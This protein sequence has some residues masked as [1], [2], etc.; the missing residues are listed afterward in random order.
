MAAL[1][2]RSGQPNDATTRF[3]RGASLLRV[4]DA[5][6]GTIAHQMGER[7][8]DQIQDL[9]I[10]FGV[11]SVHL[12]FDRSVE[13]SRT[14]RGSF[15]HAFP[16]GCM[17]VFITSCWTWVVTLDKRLEFGIIVPAEDFE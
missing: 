8:F 16:I 9:P 7:I 1:L 6:V 11:G 14:M 15:C 2:A 5:V 17:R 4:I 3:A 12:Q 13:R 10:Q